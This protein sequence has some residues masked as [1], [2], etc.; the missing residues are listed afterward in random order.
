MQV[1]TS[2]YRLILLVDIGVKQSPITTGSLAPAPGSLG[3][4]GWSKSQRGAALTE[5]ARNIVF[6]GSSRGPG[7]WT[8][9][10]IP[11]LECL[12]HSIHGWRH[13]GT[14][15]RRPTLPATDCKACPADEYVGSYPSFLESW[16]FVPG[17]WS[18]PG[19]H[20]PPV[21]PGPSN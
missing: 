7:T 21:R 16:T 10:G 17:I 9:N 11:A 20:K 6:I 2:S 4:Q 5:I 19:A 12:T 3:P 15:T 14:H 8:N 1:R 13:T 18:C